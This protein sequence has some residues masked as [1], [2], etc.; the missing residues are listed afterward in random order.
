[1]TGW[2]ANGMVLDSTVAHTGSQSLVLREGW[3]IPYAQRA[4]YNVANLI[5]GVYTVGVWVKLE[6]VAATRGSG[7]RV[8]VVVGGITIK[9]NPLKGTSDWQHLEIKKIPA[10]ALSKGSIQLEDYGHT[11]GVAW[12][13]DV[14]F[15]REERLVEAFLR[16]PNYRGFLFDDQPQEVRFSV[17]TEIGRAALEIRNGATIVYSGEHEDGIVTVD[18]SAWEPGVYD[19]V[20]SAGEFQH[21]VWRIVKGARHEDFTLSFDDKGYAR[22]KGKRRF[23]LGVYDSALAYVATAAKWDEMLDS[24]RRL[25]ELPVNAYLNYHYFGTS[26][27]Y[28]LPLYD[29]LAARRIVGFGG[30][31]C[32]ASNTV[33]QQH[34]KYPFWFFQAPESD[35]LQRIGNPGFAGWYLADE[36]RGEIAQSAFPTYDRMRRL[37][38]TGTVFNVLL[39]DR[40]GLSWKYT[41]DLLSNDPYPLFGAEP[42]GGYPLHKVAD[43]VERLGEDSEWSRPLNTVIQF[44]K[45][46]N[47][48]RWPTRSE[49]R[50]MSWMAVANGSN[51]LWYW[52]LGARALAWVCSGW[53][54]EKVRLF[55]DLKFVMHEIANLEPALIGEDRPELVGVDNPA[56]RYRVK[57]ADTGRSM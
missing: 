9:S 55:E 35:V 47:Q 20:W 14:T 13:D 38:P 21:P 16:Y 39:P 31:N 30:A 41:G 51:G 1:M 42:A 57:V 40:S 11:D 33:E 12:F 43:A 8:V 7:V 5:P 34:A 2:S 26:N 10:V 48:S 18:A 19:A 4:H 50:K 32:F 49:L 15:C 25:F 3:A 52:S 29:A 56:I 23:I 22:V 46:N 28:M 36:C 44:F 27:Q 37:N 54:E 6:N 24:G 45:F 53:C 17:K